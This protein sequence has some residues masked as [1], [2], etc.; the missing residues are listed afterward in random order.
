M[1]HA[2]E[3]R[4]RQAPR[5]VSRRL[6]DT[7]GAGAARATP[8]PLPPPPPPPPAGRAPVSGR[9]RPGRAARF[10]LAAVFSALLLAPL[11]AFGQL[12]K[13]TLSVE[14]AAAY[15]GGR[16]A[17][18]VSVPS[19]PSADLVVT[20]N[21]HDNTAENLPA[22]STVTDGNG[23]ET[24]LKE[25]R[26]DYS[27][28]ET[29]TIPAGETSVAFFV[30]LLEDGLLELGSGD[31][32]TGED[33]AIS[34]SAAGHADSDRVAITIYDANLTLNLENTL[35][36]L[37]EGG[38]GVVVTVA[39]SKNPHIPV[40]GMATIVTFAGPR[41]Y[42][43]FGGPDGDRPI[44]LA[45][46]G[47]G[48]RT[49]PFAIPAGEGAYSVRLAA[50]DDDTARPNRVHRLVF[51]MHDPL[52]P[53]GERP[54]SLEVIITEDDDAADNRARIAM[55]LAGLEAGRV[56]KPANGL[57]VEF[58]D[59]Y[60]GRALAREGAFQLEFFIFDRSGRVGDTPSCQWT[61]TLPPGPAVAIS[62][63]NAG[64]VDR[65]RCDQTGGMLTYCYVEH[66]GGRPAGSVANTFGKVSVALPVRDTGGA[67]IEPATLTG[68]GKPFL[69]FAPGTQEIRF[70]TAGAAL[71]TDS[72]RRTL[73]M[74]LR[75][76]GTRNHLPWNGAVEEGGR[77]LV[78]VHDTTGGGGAAG[79]PR[80]ALCASS[81]HASEYEYG[82][83]QSRVKRV[84]LPWPDD[85]ATHMDVEFSTADDDLWESKESVNIRFCPDLDPRYEVA[86]DG[87]T[88]LELKIEGE[89]LP[90]FRARLAPGTEKTATARA[91]GGVDERIV[92]AEGGHADIEI[93]LLDTLLGPFL[94]GESADFVFG[95]IGRTGAVNGADYALALAGGTAPGDRLAAAD[96]VAEST[97]G[98]VDLIRVRF[99]D[100]SPRT[101]TLRVR[102]IDDTGSDTTV[103][104][105]AAASFRGQWGAPLLELGD[106]SDNDGDF[107]RLIYDLVFADDDGGGATPTLGFLPGAINKIPEISSPALP[108]LRLSR[109]HSRDVDFTVEIT[110]GTAEG[111]ADYVVPTTWTHTVPAGRTTSHFPI[112]MIDDDEWEAEET[113]TLRLAS[114]SGGAGVGDVDTATVGIIDDESGRAQS[115]KPLA[116]GFAALADAVDEGPGAK[117]VFRLSRD[118]G[119]PN[120]AA[121]HDWA[122]GPLSITVSLADG[123]AHGRYLAQAEIDK[124]P[125]TVTIPTNTEHVDIEIPIDD[126]RAAEADGAVALVA[127]IS[128]AAFYADRE[129]K[130]S[131]SV[132]DDDSPGGALGNSCAP[133]AD[134]LVN[135]VRRYYDDNKLRSDRNNGENWL[136]VLVAL[137]VDVSAEAAVPPA[138]YTAAEARDSEAVWDGWKPVREE[139]ERLEACAAPVAPA[140]SIARKAGEPGLL[141]EGQPAVFVVTRS[142]PHAEF[143]DGP[144][145]VPL[146]VSETGDFVAAADEGDR[147][148][149]IPAGAEAAE[150]AVA[151]VDDATE[152]GSGE[153]AVALRAPA[154]GAH[155]IAGA[156]SEASATVTDDGDDE[157]RGIP[158]IYLAINSGLTIFED[159]EPPEDGDTQ[160]LITVRRNSPAAPLDVGFRVGGTAECGKD[161]T[162]P[163]I[164][165][166]SDGTAVGRLTLPAEIPL[167]EDIGFALH[168]LKD[169]DEEDPAET[170]TFSLV[171]SDGYKIYASG[172]IPFPT[173]FVVN[174]NN[175]TGPAQFAF[176]GDPLLGEDLTVAKTADDPDG[177]GAFR[178][179]WGFKP[180]GG[181]DFLFSYARNQPV[182]GQN[183]QTCRIPAYSTLTPGGAVGTEIV[184]GRYRVTIIYTDGTGF[185][186][187]V[188]LLSG[189]VAVGSGFPSLSIADFTARAGAAHIAALTLSAPLSDDMFA[190]LAT[191]CAAAPVGAAHFPAGATEA[192]LA[193]PVDPGAGDC[194]IAVSKIVAL[195]GETVVAGRAA[196]GTIT[197]VSTQSVRAFAPPPAAQPRPAEA[198]RAGPANPSLVDLARELYESSRGDIGR[199]FGSR[200]L[201][202]LIALGA[203]EDGMYMPYTAAEAAAALA[204]TGHS[205]WIPIRE[206]L[207]RLGLDAGCVAPR[208]KSSVLERARG[209]AG[210]DGR[211]QDR[212]RMVLNALNGQTPAAAAAD[213]ENWRARPARSAPDRWAP[214]VSA[215]GCIEVNAAARGR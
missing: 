118:P 43:L 94:D 200:W 49:F 215:L 57:A 128:G 202:V 121:S 44:P 114:V 179:V 186:E 36:I 75:E 117:A 141:L 150:F 79:R 70:N 86:G 182:C 159:P 177:N 24:V 48:N 137:G 97:E 185:I 134:G 174:D 5:G 135:M 100:K 209:P 66:P 180:E 25:A 113:I 131:V 56:A 196:A 164:T 168:F 129:V 139:L 37:E 99:T 22:G 169:D 11:A 155:T 107:G 85:N 55:S 158:Q 143:K 208:L 138:P 171:G 2:T 63:T 42:A 98:R 130:A 39:K 203:A 27:L 183:V 81:P 51:R 59:D 91:A 95:V 191:D 142:S 47:A 124:F 83:Y 189:P 152:E 90:R 127:A 146:R 46:D 133:T 176:S 106:G 72:A 119:D 187:R 20:L 162:A 104:R 9:P 17:A 82:F 28:L 13:I 31:E 62:G 136:R 170:A 161:Y 61:P 145:E 111:G 87:V 30:N 201:R 71:D 64:G 6:R 60:L 3:N 165:C 14:E 7:P 199:N 52:L 115:Q 29:V 40:S 105:L 193:V 108:V 188:E 154:G 147:S 89:E 149:T 213:V 144:L 18:T 151:T 214:A 77:Y 116:F 88:A 69:S 207:E 211:G 15:E 50:A 192:G 212:W 53:E 167:F 172:L 123:G 16:I 153:I 198:A 166:Q 178:Y 21:R 84:T 120:T 194:K 181:D 68:S 205:V 58:A 23:V 102:A 125:M 34:A 156:G 109:I 74:G 35:I 122:P 103:L 112:Y 93:T 4:A 92:I 163:F 41:D 204:E 195:G 80:V 157:G 67:R 76:W 54:A 140:V 65:C 110:G 32:G 45:V 190:V 175:S 126:D 10:R 8:P 96:R 19:A 160:F 73:R 210:P 184:G 132:R 197:Q 33:F 12:P 206:E 1:T 26:N 148:V 173:S 38:E 78:R 101:A